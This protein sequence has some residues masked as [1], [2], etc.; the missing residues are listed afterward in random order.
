VTLF[1]PNGLYFEIGVTIPCAIGG[2]CPLWSI[3]C[4]GPGIEVEIVTQYSREIMHHYVIINMFF[5]QTLVFP[6]AHWGSEFV[7][8]D[9]HPGLPRHAHH[10]KE[11]TIF[12]VTGGA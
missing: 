8:E 5:F 11:G 7:G 9:W 4:C 10:S 2:N 1:Y 6:L 3:I 12:W